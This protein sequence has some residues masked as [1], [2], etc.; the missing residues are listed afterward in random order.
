MDFTCTDADAEFKE[1]IISLNDTEYK[2]V[3]TDDN[4]TNNEEIMNAL[5]ETNNY[6]EITLFEEPA[7]LNGRSLYWRYTMKNRSIPPNKITYHKATNSYYVAISTHGVCPAIPYVEAVETIT[8]PFVPAVIEKTD[9]GYIIGG[10]HCIV[11]KTSMYDFID[12]LV[13][14]EFTHPT[15]DDWLCSTSS[16]QADW[17]SQEHE[18]YSSGLQQLVDNLEFAANA[19]N[20]E[21]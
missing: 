4:W 21:N 13:K 14:N 2:P 3:Y 1:I 11:D 6:D 9:D 16:H 18:L 7:Q 15:I 8:Y 17:F 20:G 5:Y 10:K 12:M 19:P